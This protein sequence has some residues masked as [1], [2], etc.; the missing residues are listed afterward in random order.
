MTLNVCF[1]P[2]LYDYYTGENSIVVIVDVFRATTSICAA[3]HN[4]AKS[5]RTVASVLEAKQWQQKGFLIAAERNT[6]KCDFADFGNSP[7]DFLPEKVSGKEIVFTT[8]NG[9]MAADTAK[10]A[11][12]IIIGS[13]S[14]ISKVAEFCASQNKNI[15]ILCSGWNNRFCIEDTLFAGAL[16]EKLRETQNFSN[17]S[18]AVTVAVELWQVAKL[19]LFEYICNSEHFERLKK[20]GLENSVD[21]CITND[22]APVLPKFN[23][24]LGVFTL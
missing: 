20:N 4:G 9:T 11:E 5:V 19:N 7:F 15:T 3:F 24:K 23:K 2:A 13:F 1:S 10:N 8:T 22:L 16:A 12:E 6:Q 21:Y 17:K 18:D 14:N